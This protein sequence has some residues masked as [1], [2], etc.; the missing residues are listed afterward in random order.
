MKKLGFSI[1]ISNVLAIVVFE[2]LR[3]DSSNL[4]R[5]HQSLGH[6]RHKGITTE[7]LTIPINP[8]NHILVAEDTAKYAH[9]YKIPHEGQTAYGLIRQAHNE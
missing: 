2:K 4:S 8:L 5:E 9:N 6:L 3:G 7:C 1:Y